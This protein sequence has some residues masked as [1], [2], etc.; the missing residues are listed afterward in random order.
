MAAIPPT[1]RITARFTLFSRT[2]P[3]QT[4]GFDESQFESYRQFGS[5]PP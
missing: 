3:R 1:S 4:N 5:Q 2:N